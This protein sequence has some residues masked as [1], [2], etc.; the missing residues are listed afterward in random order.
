[1]PVLGATLHGH[2]FLRNAT[3]ARPLR[4]VS[5]GR[6]KYPR[7]AIP[8]DPWPKPLILSYSGPPSG[9]ASFLRNR[10]PIEGDS[11]E[12][13]GLHVRCTFTHAF[14]GQLTFGDIAP[15]TFAEIEKLCGISE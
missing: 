2:K 9:G 6:T 15:L 8:S 5:P 7:T 4:H 13:T 14:A 10:F 3:G 12:A 11:A 1:M